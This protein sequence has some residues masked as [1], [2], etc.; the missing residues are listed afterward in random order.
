VDIEGLLRGTLDMVAAQAHARA[1]SVNL[2]VEGT[3]KPVNLNR[4][5]IQQALLNLFQNAIEAL[6]R[7]R[8]RSRT[9]DVRCLAD[10]GKEDLTIR[11]ED[12]GPGMELE[13]RRKIFTPFFTTRKHGTGLG[14]MIANLV[15]ES[16]GGQIT[17]ESLSPFGTAFV[18]RLR[19]D[20]GQPGAKAP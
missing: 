5:Q 16:H 15:L 7:V 8:G 2:A 1:I 6:G 18:I 9:L 12:N 19:Y 4:V 14:L 11:V 3:L 10:P 17:V 13:H 20:G